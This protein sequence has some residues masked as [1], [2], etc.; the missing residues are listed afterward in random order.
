MHSRPAR[1]VACDAMQSARVPNERQAVG[2]LADAHAPEHA[3]DGGRVGSHLRYSPPHRTRTFGALPP[4][5]E[6]VL[7]S[8]LV[9][10][11]V[12]PQ[13]LEGS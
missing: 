9:S 11:G 5:A 4:C 10:G 3:F 1:H 7:G 8:H 6:N 2:K 13:R 12:R